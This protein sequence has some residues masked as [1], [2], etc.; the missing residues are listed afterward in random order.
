MRNRFT[1]IALFLLVLLGVSACSEPPQNRDLVGRWLH[2]TERQGL[3]FSEEGLLCRYSLSPQKIELYQYET[4]DFLLQLK[5]LRGD[6]KEPV[7]TGIS[8]N[9]AVLQL[10]QGEGAFSNYEKAPATEERPWP[11]LLGLWQGDGSRTE[12][13]LLFT[14]WGTVYGQKRLPESEEVKP[15]W[16]KFEI[17]SGF[18]DNANSKRIGMWGLHGDTA[19]SG[20]KK[21][22]ELDSES[23]RFDG[24]RYVR[25]KDISGLAK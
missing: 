10:S 21:K 1:R 2:R 17:Y 3:D 23:L 16:A 24:L 11:P 4:E 19:L 5:P 13:F 20:N 6:A 18:T 25:R 8:L 14:A 9:G 7:E 12:D 15:L 22:I